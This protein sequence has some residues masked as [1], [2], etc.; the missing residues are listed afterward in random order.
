MSMI[1][2]LLVLCCM[3][4]AVPLYLLRKAVNADDDVGYLIFLIGT[5]TI[6]ILFT[7]LLDVN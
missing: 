1:I 6:G 3:F 2:V 7:G 4:I 5:V